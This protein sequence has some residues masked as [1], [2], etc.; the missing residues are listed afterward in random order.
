MIVQQKL[1]RTIAFVETPSRRSLFSK[2]ALGNREAALAY[3]K[4]L[5]EYTDTGDAQAFV[6]H[7]DT[8]P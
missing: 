8:R 2:V 7:L 1:D 5:Y 4:A 6:N 3:T